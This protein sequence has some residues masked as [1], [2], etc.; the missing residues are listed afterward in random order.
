MRSDLLGLVSRALTR[1]LSH[2]LGVLGSRFETNGYCSHC[3]VLFHLL[4]LHA[5][6]VMDDGLP[7]LA[8]LHR[9]TSQSL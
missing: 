5:F 7:L 9:Y 6:H 3:R 1:L 4:P 8:P 2:R